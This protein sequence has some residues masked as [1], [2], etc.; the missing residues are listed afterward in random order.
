M[1]KPRD[2]DAYL[3]GVPDAPRALLQKLREEV[4]ALVPGATETISYGLPTI[5]YWGRALIYFGAAKNHVAIYGA[6]PEAMDAKLLA[7]YDTSKGTIR[8]PL[9]KPIP[10]ALVKKLVKARRA[11]IEAMLAAKKKA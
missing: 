5:K 2:I 7:A 10:V 1:N 9:D 3:A 11:E 8:F 6:I 4:S